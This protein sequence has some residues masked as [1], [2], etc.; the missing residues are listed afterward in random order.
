M[1]TNTL[2]PNYV[3]MDFNTIKTNLQ[4]L[5]ATNPVFK[6]YDYEGSNITVIIELIAYLG[7][8]N[9]Y[10]MNMIAKNQYIPTSNMYETT[11]MLSQLGGY[12]PK[13]TTSAQ[14][15]ITLTLSSAAVSADIGPYG[16]DEQFIIDEWSKISCIGSIVDPTT[17]ESIEFISMNPPMSFL[18]DDVV[19]AS[20]GTYTVSLS[21]REG[22][23]RRYDYTGSDVVENKIYLP[24][25]TFD[26]DDDLDD[27]VIPVQLYV[28]EIKWTRINDW[29]EYT[30]TNDNVYMLKYDKYQRYYIEFS[31][32]RNKP[33]NIDEISMYLLLSAGENGNIASELLTVPTDDF[34]IR[35]SNGSS[36]ST[37]TYVLT[38]LTAAVGGSP[39]ETVEEVKENTLGVIHSQYRNVTQN[40]YIS[41]L[42]TRSDII[43]A[44]VWGEQE[45]NPNG[46]VQDYNKVYISLVPSI[47]NSST[48]VASAGLSATSTEM[49]TLPISAISYTPSWVEDISE[50]L[51]PRKILT[52]YEHYMVPELLYFTFTIGLKIKT[53]YSYVTVKND[54]QS[55][56]EY[57][58]EEYNRSFNETISFIDIT[59][60]LLD[61]SITSPDNTFANIRGLRA[62]IMRDVDIVVFSTPTPYYQSYATYLQNT[63]DIPPASAGMYYESTEVDSLGNHLYPYY[64]EGAFTTDN[65]LRT[66]Q[67][68]HKQF[69]QVFMTNN[70]FIMEQ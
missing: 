10:Y 26:Y 47:W 43:V 66:L 36:L 42:E 9:T 17:G 52:C 57:Y 1:S 69:P 68:G 59:E 45:Q 62:L 2:T 38:N 67:L 12:N 6:D 8:L 53:N 19:N 29:F 16:V 54:V 7:M 4:S 18:I 35:S 33:I 41:H 70:T 22:K 13:G 56:L 14:T 30:D 20:G 21:A 32:T 63:A 49:S 48:V 40:D 55:K 58:F 31:D 27:D 15:T 37:S 65:K 5:L 46:S 34:I 51:K 25:E 61:S 11:H 24:F 44:N 50:Y 64:V 23:V 60:Y 3:D 28:N 39:P